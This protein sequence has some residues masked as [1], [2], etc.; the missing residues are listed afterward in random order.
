MRFR[1]PAL[2]VAVAAGLALASPLEAQTKAPACTFSGTSPT[3]G[4]DS[5]KTVGGKVITYYS[6]KGLAIA[7][8]CPP[9]LAADTAVLRA[10]RDSLSS[11]RTDLS[12]AQGLIILRGQQLSDTT[13]ALK[14]ARDS[15]AKLTVVV[16]PKPPVDTGV[17]TPPPTAGHPNKPANYTKVL[18][19][20]RFATTLP[21][22]QGAPIGDGSGW[23]VNNGG[24]DMTIVQDPEKGSVLQWRYRANRG[25]PGSSFNSGLAFFGCPTSTRE[26][27]IDFSVWHS[28]DF[29]WNRVANKL[30]YVEPGNIVLESRVDADNYLSMAGGGVPNGKISSTLRTFPLNRWIRVT[31]QVVRG[32]NG[33]IKVW[34]DNALVVSYTGNVPGTGSYC[35]LKLDSEWGGGSGPTSRD[36]YRRVD[37]IHIAVPPS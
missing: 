34:A 26:F 24:G 23:S 14:V 36:S 25:T 15:I 32:P 16:P 17:V 21:V 8:A 5:T 9:A 7:A 31:L 4:V 12:T 20:Y 35:E 10:L 2:L 18:T 6:F 3:R 1:I 19:D 11:A 29:E 30:F 33:L 22:R 28:A 13:A 27:Y 37:R